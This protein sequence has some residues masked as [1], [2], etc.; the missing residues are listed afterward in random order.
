MQTTLFILRFSFIIFHFAE[1]SF[2]SPSPTVTR[3]NTES[4]ATTTKWPWE[5]VVSYV[6]CLGDICL[7]SNESRIQRDAMIGCQGKNAAGLLQLLKF[8]LKVQPGTKFV[9][10]LILGFVS[11]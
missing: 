10:I 6:R 7:H 2:A 3:P 4:S 5:L 11:V 1:Q 8:Q 9:A